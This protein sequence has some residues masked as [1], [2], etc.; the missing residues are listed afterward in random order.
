[1]ADD[2][3][4]PVDLADQPELVRVDKD[5]D[6]SIVY[7][8]VV[9][10]HAPERS[11]DFCFYRVRRNQKMKILF[12][13]HAERNRHSN[14]HRFVFLLNGVRV[15]PEC[16]I[17][18]LDYNNSCDCLK[19]TPIEDWIRKS[20]QLVNARTIQSNDLELPRP[21][22]RIDPH[23]HSLSIRNSLNVEQIRHARYT[24]RINSE[25]KN[26]WGFSFRSDSYYEEETILTNTN[27]SISQKTTYVNYAQGHLTVE[28]SIFFRQTKFLGDDIVKETI[29]VCRVA[30]GNVHPSSHANP[31]WCLP[32]VKM[33]EEDEENP[34]AFDEGYANSIDEKSFADFITRFGTY[35]IY[36]ESVSKTTLR[37][38]D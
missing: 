6:N 14:I 16:T 36:V 35:R 17:G 13:G 5:D 32:M 20:V 3:A 19:L 24:Y 18:S 28:G 9:D 11:S 29:C 33:H 26:N 1:M 34:D 23:L 27:P 37:S 8:T 22:S 12:Q 7:V 30:N 21:S 2:A 31:V 38:N 25:W 15:T 10:I 4:A